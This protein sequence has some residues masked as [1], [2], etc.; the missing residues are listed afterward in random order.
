MPC[1]LILLAH[2]HMSLMIEIPQILLMPL[3]D[4]F[5]MILTVKII[6][7]SAP[8]IHEEIAQIQ[9]LFLSGGLIEPHQRHLRNLMSRISLAFSL[10]R[11]KIIVYVI[12]KPFRRIEK[13]IL[14]RSLIIRHRPLSQMAKA[15]QFMMVSEVGED[16]VFP[17]DDVVGIQISVLLLGRADNIYGIVRPFFQF[18]VWMLR[19]RICHRLHPFIKVTVLKDKAVKLILQMLHVLRKGLKST[20]CILR[21]L[22]GFSLLLP[23]LILFPRHLEIAH[24]ETG[25]RPLYLIVQSVPLIRQDLLTYQFHLI[26]PERVCDPDLPE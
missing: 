9:I 14:A 26:F 17:V 3:L 13:L 1:H 25:L 7:T 5:G 11:S 10:L 24:A 20:E 15:V 21:F 23:L 18:R 19:Q 12:R 4:L 22:K 6:G 2:R 16:L 8:L